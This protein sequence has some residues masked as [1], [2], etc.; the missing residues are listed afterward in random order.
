MQ[1]VKIQIDIRISTKNH[2]TFMICVC[3]SLDLAKH[4]GVCEILS[5]SLSFTGN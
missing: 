3:F 4:L 1:Q 2:T 5:I